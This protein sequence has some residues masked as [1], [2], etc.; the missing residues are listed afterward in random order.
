MLCYA[1]LRVGWGAASVCVGER[2]CVAIK[3]KTKAV[4]C[5]MLCCAVQ[6][7]VLCWAMRC[8]AVLCCNCAKC[9]CAL[10]GLELG[11]I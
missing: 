3:V 1:V 5:C 6:C 7:V 2:V 11:L 4:L 9:L 8:C 10:L